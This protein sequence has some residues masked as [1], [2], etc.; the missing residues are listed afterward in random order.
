MEFSV[1]IPALNEEEHIEACLKSILK[2]TLPRDSYEIIVSDGGSGDRTA[3]ISRKYAD[4]VVV[5]KKRGIWWGRNQGA[6]IA[7]GTY[8][9][10]IDADTRIKEDYLETAKKHL[11]LGVVGLTAGFEIEGIG[12]KMKI[13]EN[14]GCCFFWLSSKF[15]NTSLIGINL[16]VPRDVF[17]RVGGF[18]DYALE[19]AAF[20]RDLK[21]VGRTCFLMERKVVTSARRLEAYGAIGLCKYYFELGMMDGGRINS[22]HITKYMKYQEYKPVRMQAT[23]PVQA[24]GRQRVIER[25]ENF[26]TLGK[27]RIRRVEKMVLKWT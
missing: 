17:R 8:L 20:D 22:P 9:V 25:C 21:K 19:D 23:M 18:K 5:S 7:K 10:F 14:L 3:E 16:C 27:Q 15:G 24:T 13:F 26:K 11:D 12:L 6:K 2:Q 1:I 4:R